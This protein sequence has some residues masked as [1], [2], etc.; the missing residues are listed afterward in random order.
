MQYAFI[1]G[2]L[3]LLEFFFNYTVCASTSEASQPL[4]MSIGADERFLLRCTYGG[5]SCRSAQLDTTESP[6]SYL[7][8]RYNDVLGFLSIF[9]QKYF[10]TCHNDERVAVIEKGL[11]AVAYV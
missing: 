2:L 11:N 9:I 5:L 1:L 7:L 6:C 10:R 4:R 3:H 8:F